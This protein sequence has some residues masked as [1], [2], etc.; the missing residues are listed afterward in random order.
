MGDTQATSD[1]DFTLIT[2]VVE[3]N[4]RRSLQSDT[5]WK[6]SGVLS[7]FTSPYVPPEMSYIV[8]LSTRMAGNWAEGGCDSDGAVGWLGWKRAEN[9]VAAAVASGFD[10]AGSESPTTH[11]KVLYREEFLI[12]SIYG[13]TRIRE[14]ALKIPYLSL[15]LRP[16]ITI[17]IKICDKGEREQGIFPVGTGLAFCGGGV[18]GEIGMPFHIEGPFLQNPGVRHLPLP[19]SPDTY[20]A[21]AE[22]IKQVW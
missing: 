19:V 11:F 10:S 21:N 1:F 2:P 15:K 17:A 6:R 8:V 18:I 9:M 22:Q 13:A 3:R 16:F 7:I 12:S 4:A 14:L 20:L 5:A